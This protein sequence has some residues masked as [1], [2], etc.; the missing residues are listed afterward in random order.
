[1]G[2]AISAAADARR[3][4]R[5]RPSNTARQSGLRLRRLL[6]RQAMMDGTFGIRWLHR[7][8][9]SGVQANRCATVPRSVSAGRACCAEAG[10]T[11]LVRAAPTINTAAPGRDGR[12]ANIR[13]K[14]TDRGAPVNK[15][16]ARGMHMSR[17]GKGGDARSHLSPLAA[18]CGER[19]T[20]ERSVSGATQ[21]G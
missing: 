16:G 11:P 1:M 3:R 4:Q 12:F 6:L 21:V 19:S 14:E 18:A 5:S 7:R 17:R 10:A 8:K 9:T 20:C 2:I 15:R 13:L